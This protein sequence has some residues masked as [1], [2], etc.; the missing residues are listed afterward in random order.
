[1]VTI[2]A[3]PHPT[4]TRS[5]TAQVQATSNNHRNHPLPPGRQHNFLQ[6]WT[7]PIHRTNRTNRGG[8]GRQN[9]SPGYHWKTPAAYAAGPGQAACP[10]NGKW[11]YARPRHGPGP[12]I[13]FSILLVGQPPSTPQGT[14]QILSRA[15]TD[16]HPPAELT[17]YFPTGAARPRSESSTLVGQRCGAMGQ[18]VH[19]PPH[20]AACSVGSLLPA[21]GSARGTSPRPGTPTGLDTTKTSNLLMA[22]SPGTIRHHRISANRRPTHRIE[23][24]SPSCWL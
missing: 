14:A 8:W 24:E 13:P 9:P 1:M 2:P 15:P 11:Q 7:Y 21:T 19:R 3:V 20:H 16:Y 23:N 5:P 22:P 6:A 10:T 12:K 4:T 17:A 18:R